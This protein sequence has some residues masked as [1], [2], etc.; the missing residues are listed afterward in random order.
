MGPHHPREHERESLHESRHFFDEIPIT[1]RT[2]MLQTHVTFSCRNQCEN[3][4]S[5]QH[6][7]PRMS[8]C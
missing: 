6:P 7:D 3:S 1:S 5:A 8:G 2:L 4:P